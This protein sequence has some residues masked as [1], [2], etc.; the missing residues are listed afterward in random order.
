MR[1]VVKI[2][3][4]FFM[5][6]HD[7]CSSIN[8]RFHCLYASIYRTTVAAKHMR[9]YSICIGTVCHFI[10]I[11][12]VCTRIFHALRVAVLLIAIVQIFFFVFI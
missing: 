3:Y 10:R 12:V 7:H 5:I 9:I 4:Y 8:I 11:F 1:I 2:E 6:Q